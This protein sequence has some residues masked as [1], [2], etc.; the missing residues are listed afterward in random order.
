[1]TG[2]LPPDVTANRVIHGDQVTEQD[3][4]ELAKDHKKL[5]EALGTAI[6]LVEGLWDQ[7]AM[8]DNWFVEDLEKVKKI[9]KGDD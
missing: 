6:S 1:M 8:E 3:L 7:Q 5:K 9:F 2:P 4:K